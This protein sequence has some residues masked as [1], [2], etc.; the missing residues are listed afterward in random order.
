MKNGKI[1]WNK[2][3]Y[4]D[5]EN[6]LIRIKR[7]IPK[8]GDIVYAREGTYGEAVILPQGFEFALGQRTMLL[9]TVSEKCDNFFIWYFIKIIST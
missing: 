5:Y 9:R 4:L 8:A 7:L 2:M 6:Y 3:K 1:I